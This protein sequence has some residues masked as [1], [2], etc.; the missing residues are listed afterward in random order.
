ME[1]VCTAWRTALRDVPF[2]FLAVG[3]SGEVDDIEDE[4]FEEEELLHVQR[5]ERGLSSASPAAGGWS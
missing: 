3:A 4:G 2:T 5:G 1:S